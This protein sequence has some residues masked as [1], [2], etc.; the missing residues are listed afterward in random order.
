VGELVA[1]GPNVMLGYLRSAEATT[2]TLRNGWLHTGDLGYQSEEGLIT[3]VDRSKDMIIR[4]GENIYSSEV[5]QVILKVP[6]IKSAA[7][8]GQ[9][10]ALFGEQVCAF[11]VTDPEQPAPTVEELDAHCRQYLADYKVPVTFRFIDT[12]P[13]TA[14]GKIM[15]ADL[16]TLTAKE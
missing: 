3:L 1:R 8:V 5:E 14:T 4:G 11:V 7:V 2:T 15:K 6:R 16:R 10:D 13:L 9:P 12:M